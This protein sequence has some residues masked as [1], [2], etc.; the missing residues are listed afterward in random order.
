M[1]SLADNKYSLERKRGQLEG[2]IPDWYT[3]QQ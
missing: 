1:V 2:T 3:T